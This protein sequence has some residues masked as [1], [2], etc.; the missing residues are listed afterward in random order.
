MSL[1]LLCKTEPEDPLL[2]YVV[3]SDSAVNSIL[4]KE[5]EKQRPM[6]YMSWALTGVEKNYPRVEKVA[7][8]V[9]ITTQKLWLYF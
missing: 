7:F 6:Y 9:V 1:P 2:L 8:I 3:V 5:R 4:I